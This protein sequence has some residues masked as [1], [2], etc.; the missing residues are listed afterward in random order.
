VRVKNRFSRLAAGAVIP[1][2]LFAGIAVVLTAVGISLPNIPAAFGSIPG[3][4]GLILSGWIFAG[5][6]CIIFS[7]FMEFVVNPKIKN[8]HLAISISGLLIS[9]TTWSVFPRGFPLTLLV[10]G[11]IVGCVVGNWLR[12]MYKYYS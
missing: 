6:Q 7:V 5:I 4:I 2:T 10:I 3:L 9:I 11:F 12:D 8:E 1:V